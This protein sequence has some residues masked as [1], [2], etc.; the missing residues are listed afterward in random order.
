MKA[1]TWMMAGVGV[2]VLAY[3]VLNDRARKTL[4]AM[5]T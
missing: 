3:I 2:G 5:M 1:L 4:R